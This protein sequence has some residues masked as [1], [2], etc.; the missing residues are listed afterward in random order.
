MPLVAVPVSV[1]VTVSGAASSVALPER[2][3]RNVPV[4]RAGLDASASIAD[5][6]TSAVGVAVAA[7]VAGILQLH[8]GR[9][10]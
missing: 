5:T 6:D 4:L 7:T 8:F 9:F 10:E 1:K 2:V 3:R